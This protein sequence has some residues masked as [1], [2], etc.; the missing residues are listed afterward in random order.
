MAPGPAMLRAFDRPGLDPVRAVVA[1]RDQARVG[2][3]APNDACSDR[4]VSPFF[5]SWPA[6]IRP[7]FEGCTVVSALP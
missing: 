6:T 7:A 2:P 5:P 3:N 1:P 4:E